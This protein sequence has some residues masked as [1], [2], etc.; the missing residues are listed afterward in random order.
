MGPGT[1]RDTIEAHF[2]YHNWEKYRS[3]GTFLQYF[4]P[5]MEIFILVEAVKDRNRQEEAHH[6]FTA[7]LEHDQLLEDWEAV[8]ARWEQEVHPREDPSIINPF[9]IEEECK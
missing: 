9:A 4:N 5:F 1:Y 7:S 2:G 3:M 8:C 6:G